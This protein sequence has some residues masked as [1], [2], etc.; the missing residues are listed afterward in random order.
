[1]KPAEARAI[2]LRRCFGDH[3][4]P[5]CARIWLLELPRTETIL[6]DQE[7]RAELDRKQSYSPSGIA[8]PAGELPAQA[9]DGDRHMP[10]KDELFPSKYLKAPDVK[11]PVVLTIAN[12]PV[13]TLEYKG[14]AEDKV[15][16]HFKGTPKLLPLN[17]TNFDNVVEATGE[18]DTDHWP[19]KKVEVYATT[20]EMRGKIVDCVRIR[21]PGKAKPAPKADDDDDLADD[22][23]TLA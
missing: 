19:G 1:M 14:K 22:V 8:A 16:L 9:A 5:A 10:K 11:K 23:P 2:M 4:A 13:E 12:A 20:T 17:F 21:K 6:A 3:L 18:A 7:R 15:V